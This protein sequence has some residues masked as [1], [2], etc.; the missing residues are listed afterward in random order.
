MGALQRL[1]FARLLVHLPR[2]VILDEAISALDDANEA[3][4]YGRLKSEG[5]TLI[6]IAHRA[7]VVPLHTHV[8]QFEDDAA[9]A[10]RMFPHFS[11]LSRRVRQENRIGV[12]LAA[13]RTTRS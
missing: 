10:R 13:A 8:L 12:S 11:P 5:V 7:A 4:L 3:A 2:F 9:G 6:S 1:S